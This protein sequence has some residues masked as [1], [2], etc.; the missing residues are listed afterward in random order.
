MCI[1]DRDTSRLKDIMIR[2]E[3]LGYKYTA[4]EIL[5]YY[6]ATPVRCV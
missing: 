2:F 3:N 5:E 1:R 6:S 4:D